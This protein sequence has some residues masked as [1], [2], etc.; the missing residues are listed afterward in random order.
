[1]GTVGGAGGGA[2]GASSIRGSFGNINSGISILGD[3]TSDSGTFRTG[4]TLGG[5]NGGAA[6]LL[7]GIEGWTSKISD[8]FSVFF[9]SDRTGVAFCGDTVRGSRLTLSANLSKSRAKDLKKRP[10]PESSLKLEG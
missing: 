8:F 9:D 7:T 1:M 10:K 6:A 2:G 5:S 3:S 4:S